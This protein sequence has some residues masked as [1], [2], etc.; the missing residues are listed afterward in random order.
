MR[1]ARDLL[2]QEMIDVVNETVRAAGINP[3]APPSA[4]PRQSIAAWKIVL[5]ALAQRDPTKQDAVIAAKSYLDL[6]AQLLPRT[7]GGNR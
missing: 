2:P 7:T 3:I 5:D 4:D 1:S 6:V